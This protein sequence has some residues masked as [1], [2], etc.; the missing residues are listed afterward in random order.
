MT[1]TYR[2]ATLAQKELRAITAYTIETW[3][4]EQAAIFQRE[5]TSRMEALCASPGLGRPRDELSTGLRSVS[6][7]C[8]TGWR[9]PQLPSCRSSIRPVMPMR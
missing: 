2:V 6:T 9:T 7:F 3:G 1:L 8:F 5:L 4:A